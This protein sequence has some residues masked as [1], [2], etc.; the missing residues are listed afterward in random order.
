MMPLSK[1]LPCPWQGMPPLCLAPT[2]VLPQ[3]CATSAAE[4][5][6]AD[7]HVLWVQESGQS[8]LVFLVILPIYDASCVPQAGSEWLCRQPADNPTVDAMQDT[9]SAMKVITFAAADD[10][11]V[12]AA[13]Q[14]VAAVRTSALANFGSTLPGQHHKDRL[15][16]GPAGAGPGSRPADRRR[17]AAAGGCRSRRRL[18]A[19]SCPGPLPLACRS[20]PRLGQRGLILVQACPP[21]WSCPR[22]LD[23]AGCAAQGTAG[24]AQSLVTKAVADP[25]T[26]SAARALAQKVLSEA[27]LQSASNLFSGRRLLA[28]QVREALS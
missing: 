25:A 2:G 7:R 15:R 16:P 21:A 28:E 24:A 14:F 22:R 9:A 3:G 20:P 18:L 11:T 12:A 23:K 27:A 17:A 26:V 13:S 5:F 4:H 19:S 10:T 6:C 8:T 1:Q